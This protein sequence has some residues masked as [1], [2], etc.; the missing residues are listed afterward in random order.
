MASALKSQYKRWRHRRYWQT[1]SSRTQERAALKRQARRVAKQAARSIRRSNVQPEGHMYLPGWLG[2]KERGYWRISLG[3]SAYDGKV[4]FTR[5]LDNG[6]IVLENIPEGPA[7]LRRSELRH[8]I[9]SLDY[10]A[11]ND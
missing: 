11:Q 3:P 2:P 4:R 6:V 7:R 9:R 10:R 1:G 8:V 5:L